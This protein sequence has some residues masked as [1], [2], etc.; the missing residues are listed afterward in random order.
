MKI[1]SPQPSRLR[2][3][4]GTSVAADAAGRDLGE[5][6]RMMT[7]LEDLLSGR[8][9]A[10]QSGNL[11][12]LG[13][14]QIEIA[15]SLAGSEADLITPL[16][17]G[18]RLALVSD[19][20]THAL[21][22]ARILRALESRHDVDSL[23]LPEHPHADSDTGSR[24][25]AASA[26]ADA[27]VAVGSG[28]INDLCK[29]AAA[30]S[31]KPYAV[32]ATAPSMNGYASANAAI[33]VAGHKKTLAC[34]PPKGIFVDLAVLKAAPPRM[35]R[36]GLGDSLCRATAQ[37]DWLLA[38]LLLDQDYLDLPFQLLAYDEP[39]LFAQAD[40]LLK[41]NGETM[42]ALIRTL[43]LS[44]FGMTLARGSQPASQGEHMIG[45]YL[46]ML[47]PAGT[48]DFFHGEAI[49]LTTITMA[50][51]QEKILS[52]PA[53]TL[54][55]PNFEEEA[56]RKHFGPELGTSCWQAVQP[57]CFKPPELKQM[58][59]RLADNW[60]RWREKIR[61]IHKSAEELSA[62]MRRVGGPLVPADLGL[63]DEFYR[64]AVCHARETRDRFTFLDLA[65]MSG[66]QNALLE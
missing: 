30:Q 21:L 56:F 55:A 4:Q 27:L 38:H 48:P 15:D 63:P 9:A 54:E 19:P 23:V 6:V 65:Q 52:G 44:G 7:L 35:I 61:S 41:G 47:A 10:Q 59:A 20:T 36:S 49:A 43:L 42:A 25:L 60:P 40:G 17:F 13:T 26:N 31:D 46:E 45:H 1:K 24:I 29:Y 53:P 57:K 64:D 58:N 16:E 22:G 32:F 50:R 62:V 33:T 34:R 28:T 2:E 11:P 8:L 66:Q 5:R 14:W 3:A 37:A 39:L 12:D 51:L 18:K